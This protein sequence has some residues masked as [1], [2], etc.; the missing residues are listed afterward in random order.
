MNPPSRHREKV[1]CGSLINTTL[2]FLSVN[3]K[4]GSFCKQK[5]P[6]RSGGK[7]W[8]KLLQPPDQSFS[9]IHR[10]REQIL[11]VGVCG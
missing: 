5:I 11:E 8:A 9:L 1:A 7:K 10:H 6:P 2:F 4:K 3:L